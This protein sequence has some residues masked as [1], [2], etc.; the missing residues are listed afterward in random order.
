MLQKQAILT[1]RLVLQDDEHME[2]AE[3]I[4]IDALTD[5]SRMANVKAEQIEFVTEEIES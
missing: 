5:A 3:Q 1:V 2:D 4:V